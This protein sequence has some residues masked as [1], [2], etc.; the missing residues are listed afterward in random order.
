[1]TERMMRKPPFVHRTRT[2]SLPHN[3]EETTKFGR[4]A[5]AGR[6][7]FH[8]SSSDEHLAKDR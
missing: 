3:R 5:P 8:D 4:E 6:G 1:L 2:D 7:V